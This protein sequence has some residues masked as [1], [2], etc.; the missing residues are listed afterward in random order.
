MKFITSYRF[1]NSGDSWKLKTDE[2]GAAVINDG[3]PVYLKPDGTEVAI[4]MNQ[5]NATIGRLNAEAKAHREAKEKLEATFK[6]YEN[7]DPDK[8]RDALDKLAK[9]DAK[10][11]IDAGQVDQVKAQ[12]TAQY[13]EKLS[14]AQKER[15]AIRDQYHNTMRSNAFSRSKFIADK[16]AVPVDMIEAAFG[17]HF[18]VEADGSVR[19]YINGQPIYSPDKPGEIASFDEAL[20]VLVN[21]YSNKNAILKG[22]GASGSGAQPGNPGAGGARVITRDEFAKMSP[23]MQSK[24]AAEAREGKVQITD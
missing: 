22:T 23:V 6:R 14:A 7:I 15:D 9:L 11:L 18:Q 13:E 21:G 5:T 20:S 8:A 1:F 12:I 17:K 2:T 10:Q 19:G 16:I 3:K 24:V 4:D